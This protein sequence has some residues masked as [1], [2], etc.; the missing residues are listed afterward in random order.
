MKF[1]ILHTS[2]RPDKWREI[3]EA[4]NHAAWDPANVDYVL[5][6]DRRWGFSRLPDGSDGFFGK[7]V[8][9]TGRRCYVDGVNVAA[10]YATGDVLIVNADDQFPCE[11]WDKRLTVC[12]DTHLEKS[13]DFVIEVS[14][15]TPAEHDR[16]ILVMPILSRARYETYGYVLYPAYES[17]YSDNDFCEMARRDQCII[18]ARH[19]AFPHKHPIF[20]PSQ[21]WDTAYQEQNRKQAYDLGAAILEK[22]RE[23]NF[24]EVTVHPAVPVAAVQKQSFACLLPGENFSQAWVGGWTEI[25]A[26]LVASFSVNVQF[27]FASNVYLIRQG[28]WDTLKTTKQRPDYILMLDDDQILNLEGLKRLVR[29]LEERPD[30]DGVCG[31]AWCESSIYG[32]VPM[33]SCGIWDRDGKPERMKYEEMQAMG[34]D[35]IPISYSGFPAVVL[36][37]SVLDKAPER[38]FMPIF[39]EDLFQPYGI[40]GEDTAFF[41]KCREAGLRF[42]VDRR[43]KVPHLKLRCAEPVLGSSLE[44]VPVSTKE[45]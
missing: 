32:G 41:F 26:Q 4:W 36:R 13:G 45:Q 40:S 44:G 14:T 38:A 42:A 24:G 25:L 22:R 1:S 18:D 9:N 3:Y 2:A 33:L 19:L 6:C 43:V 12:L 5:V 34:E 27:G 10:A 30:L 20:D 28:M 37:G 17:M 23:S 21:A 15:G 31:W 8:W 7:A 35:L 29:D 11:H 16:G 39:D